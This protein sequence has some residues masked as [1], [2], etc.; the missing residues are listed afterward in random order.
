MHGRAGG[1]EA[2]DNCL[3][4]RRSLLGPAL[5]AIA[6]D[7]GNHQDL[8]ELLLEGPA[9]VV[10]RAL[11]GDPAVINTAIEFQNHP[12]AASACWAWA[13]TLSRAMNDPY[14]MELAEAR[15]AQGPLPK[16]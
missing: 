15:T 4:L 1:K 12:H 2:S 5:Y 10:K 11:A 7:G 13:E 14:L 3:E 9:A 6:H 8:I 16:H